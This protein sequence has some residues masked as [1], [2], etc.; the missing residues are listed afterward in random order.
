APPQLWHARRDEDHRH[1]PGDP[2][3]QR[4]AASHP[5]RPGADPAR[6]PETGPQRPGGPRVCARYGRWNLGIAHALILPHLATAPTPRCPC[7]VRAMSAPPA[8]ADSYPQ[9]FSTL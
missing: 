1:P 6:D 2:P 5:D 3:R 9:A 7:D 8:R 4:A